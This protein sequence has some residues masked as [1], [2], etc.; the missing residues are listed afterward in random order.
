MCCPAADVNYN[1]QKGNTHHIQNEHVTEWE[2]K[3]P[4]M[5][6]NVFQSGENEKPHFLHKQ[7]EKSVVYCIWEWLQLEP[8]VILY[9]KRS[10]LCTIHKLP[11][12]GVWTTDCKDRQCTS[13]SFRVCAQWGCGGEPRHQG[14]HLNNISGT[15]TTETIFEGNLFDMYFDF[16]FWS[17][18]VH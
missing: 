17:L 13:T 4:L 12:P 10:G 9:W 8:I 6:A 3:L 2:Q 14:D 15:K 5:T 18:P 16:S 7:E 1:F 11:P